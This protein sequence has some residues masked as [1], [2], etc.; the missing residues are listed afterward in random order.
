MHSID[1]IAVADVVLT[2]EMIEAGVMVL[3]GYDPA[4]SNE[5]DIVV[6]IFMT[7]LRASPPKGP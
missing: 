7:M 6:E 4:F 1:K 5:N 2:P 3:L